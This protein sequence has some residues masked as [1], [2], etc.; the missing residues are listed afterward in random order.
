MLPQ[1]V[2]TEFIAI[3]GHPLINAFWA[4]DLPL[5]PAAAAQSGESK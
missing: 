1:S 2:F 3:H 5:S 4:I